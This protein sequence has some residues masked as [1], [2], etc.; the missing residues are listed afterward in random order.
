MTESVGPLNIQ[1][2]DD[3]NIPVC[4]FLTE[5]EIEKDKDPEQDWKFQLTAHNYMPRK[6]NVEEDALLVYSDN[7]E[8]LQQLVKQYILPLYQNA[9][10]QLNG[11]INGTNDSLYYWDSEEELE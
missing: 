6:D 9:I 10:T 8:E 4:I 1:D 3:A 11:I 5:A 2:F 7:K